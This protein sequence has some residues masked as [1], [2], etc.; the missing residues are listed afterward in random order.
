MTRL[1]EPPPLPHEH[2]AWAMLVLPLVLGLAAAGTPAAA[3]WLV[4]PAMALLFM[5][6]YAAVA[7]ATRIVDGRKTPQGFIARRVLWAAIYIAGAVVMFA[8]AWR[9]APAGSRRDAAIAGGVT[10]ALGALHTALVFAGRDRTIPGEIVGM[11][12]LASAATLVIAMAGRPLDRRAV[13]AGLLAFLYFA[14]SLAYVRAIRG[15]W[16]GDPK[17][18]R[19]CIA[20]HVLLGSAAV[21]LAAGAFIPPVAAAAF[22]PVFA[23]TAWGLV[24]PPASLRMLGWREVGVAVT[25]ALVA[26]A[27]YRLGA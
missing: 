22:V 24:R 18:R 20:A 15:L 14:S 9:L 17:G 8:A 6:R 11:S 4:P 5:S 3:A 13:G 19:R 25:F 7:A 21:Q 12:G 2:G 27:G 23:R 1:F 26:I 10:L 16:K